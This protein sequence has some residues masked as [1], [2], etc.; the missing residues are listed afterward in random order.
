MFKTTRTNIESLNK[1][2]VNGSG[3]ERIMLMLKNPFESFVV[4]PFLFISFCFALIGAAGIFYSYAFFI[5]GFFGV[6]GM[7]F[8]P[9]ADSSKLQN[10]L[11]K[12][13]ILIQEDK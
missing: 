9:V 8:S 10:S 1:N 11:V 13:I 5:V 6:M 12:K 7:Q 4:N 3:Y 2:W